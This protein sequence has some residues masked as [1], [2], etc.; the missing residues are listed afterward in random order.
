MNY[1]RK[2]IFLFIIL[3]STTPN[4]LGQN[5]DFNP[6]L[7]FKLNISSYPNCISIDN[8]NRIYIGTDDGQ[9]FR[10]EDGGISFERIFESESHDPISC[11]LNTSY[12]K[13]YVGVSYPGGCLVISSGNEGVYESSN[14]GNSWK[15]IIETIWVNSLIENKND[16]VFVCANNSNLITD[17]YMSN[18]KGK[19]WQ[20][21]NIGLPQD[22]I[23]EFY[24]DKFNDLYAIEFHGSIYKLDL[25]KYE[26]KNKCDSVP[27]KYISN[28]AR[29][30]N[31]IE[32]ISDSETGLFKSSDNFKTYSKINFTLDQNISS[33]I[34][35]TN[36]EIFLSTAGYGMFFSADFGNSWS[37]FNKSLLNSRYLGAMAFDRKEYLYVLGHR[38]GAEN[39][40][41]NIF[42]TIK[43]DLEASDYVLYKTSS[44]TIDDQPLI[45]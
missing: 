40:S 15:R 9:V 11:I 43:Y 33:I 23:T 26:W 44:S 16:E 8:K 14:D 45:R 35:N 4:N 30:S 42:E 21:L 32:F 36:N 20:K 6:W 7:R 22:F 24:L 12:G 1:F 31:G 34:I 38:L 13:I 28:F 5:P 27:T 2:S 18:D 3:L 37:A 10:S 29:T 41:D 25:K 19:S 39:E 17:N